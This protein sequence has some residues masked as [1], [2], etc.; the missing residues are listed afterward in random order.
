MTC[1]KILVHLK[2]FANQSSASE[3]LMPSTLLSSPP[4]AWTWIASLN[5]INVFHLGLPHPHSYHHIPYAF[6]VEV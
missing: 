6:Y 4:L 3:V 2:E 5:I 1:D